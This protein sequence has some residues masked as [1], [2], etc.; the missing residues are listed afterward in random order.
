MEDE[1]I[2]NQNQKVHS[3]GFYAAT[4]MARYQQRAAVRQRHGS[5][6]HYAHL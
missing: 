3:G 6:G 1:L 2:P 4:R 5:V